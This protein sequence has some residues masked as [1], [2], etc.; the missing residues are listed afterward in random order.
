MKMLDTPHKKKSAGLTAL[1]AALLLLLF[2]MLGLTYYDPPVSYGMEVNFGT[3]AQ[4]NGKVQPKKSVQTVEQAVD[5]PQE[6]VEKEVTI[7]VFDDEE[8]NK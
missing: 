2:F 4:G 3:L 6:V 8:S 5:P 1:V 7:E